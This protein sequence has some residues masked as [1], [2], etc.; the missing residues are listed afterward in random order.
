MNYHFE[1]VK[2]DV[3]GVAGQDLFDRFTH[4]SDAELMLDKDFWSALG[5]ARHWSWNCCFLCG[6]TDAKDYVGL[7]GEHDA[8]C[9]KCGATWMDKSEFPEEGNL[10]RQWI[11][12]WHRFI[13]HLAD[14]KDADSFFKDL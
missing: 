1:Q 14:G 13:D 10:I 5:K 2:N 8:Q 3:W 11:Y 4:M 6:G 7:E 12:Q 9:I